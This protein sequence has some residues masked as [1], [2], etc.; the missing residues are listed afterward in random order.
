MGHTL[1]SFPDVKL[2]HTF[3]H[4]FMKPIFVILA[5]LLCANYTVA[6]DP[7]YSQFYHAPLQ[8]NPAMA[9]N[10]EAPFFAA[11]ARIQWPGLTKAYNTY[12]LSYDQFL[13]ASNS[14]IGFA[15]LSDNSGDGALKNTKISGIYSYNLRIKRD[16]YVRGGIEAG[17]IQKSLDWDKLIF[18]DAIDPQFGAVSP[19]G[20]R[21]PSDEVQPGNTNRNAL[22]LSVGL[23]YYSPN[24]YFGIAVDHLNNP[25]DEFLTNDEKNYPGI[26]PRITLHAGYEY[27]LAGYNNRGN[28]SFISPHFLFVKQGGFNQLNIGL[29]L[30]V[31]S[32]IGGIAFR[33]SN[34]NGDAVIFS[35]GARLGLTKLVYSFDFTV[36]D[37]GIAQGGSHELGMILNLE[38]NAPKKYDINDCLNIFR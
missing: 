21:Y 15:V 2:D 12:S 18:G 7:V 17:L 31:N 32:I 34:T 13:P 8:L 27:K 20:T 4:R 9:G 25:P 1:F 19:G 23:L 30:E 36:S 11:N 33:N 24:L 38:G 10:N 3:E 22:D 6:Q 37:L 29:G 28:P 14:G 5:T 26:P 16:H 35:A